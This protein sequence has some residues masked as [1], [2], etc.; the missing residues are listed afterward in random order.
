[1]TVIPNKKADAILALAEKYYLE[2]SNKEA[3]G[4]MISMCSEEE[5]VELLA[6]G[7]EAGKKRFC[8]KLASKD[9][10]E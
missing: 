3:L 8:M 6:N 1:M 4:Y 9:I 2:M 7:V 10:N 5:I